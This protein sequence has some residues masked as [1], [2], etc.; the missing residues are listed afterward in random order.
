MNIRDIDLNL[1]RLFDAVYRFG[2]ELTIPLDKDWNRH[3]TEGYADLKLW[4]ET[5]ERAKREGRH[6]GPALLA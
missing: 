2:N 3:T 6:L 4:I 1:L 5:K